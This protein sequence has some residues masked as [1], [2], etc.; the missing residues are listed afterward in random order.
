MGKSGYFLPSDSHTIGIC[1]GLDICSVKSFGKRDPPKRRCL[2][3]PVI[4]RAAPQ[5]KQA[6]LFGASAAIVAQAPPALAETVP[7]ADVDAAIESVVGVVKVTREH[8]KCDVCC[9]IQMRAQK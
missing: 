2:L 8:E 5:W 1:Y 7:D 6:G 3:L 4:P 9:I